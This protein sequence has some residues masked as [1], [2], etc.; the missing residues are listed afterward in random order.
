MKTFLSWARGCQFPREDISWWFWSEAP[1]HAFA[2]LPRRALGK[3]RVF[4]LVRYKFSHV[5]QQIFFPVTSFIWT[6][7]EQYFQRPMAQSFTIMHGVSTCKISYVIFTYEE[8]ASC[9]TEGPG[10]TTQSAS[11]NTFPHQP[12]VCHSRHPI[13]W[14]WARRSCVTFPRIWSLFCRWKSS[15]GLRLPP[16]AS[17]YPHW[18]WCR[19]LVPPTSGWG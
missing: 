3:D 16:G 13:L 7:N 18:Q 6:C 10:Q 17:W 11:H 2:K 19:H 12:S 15:C 14:P 9:T 5:I 1:F 4:L 8:L